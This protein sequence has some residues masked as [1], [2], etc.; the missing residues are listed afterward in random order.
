MKNDDLHL[1]SREEQLYLQILEDLNKPRGDGLKVDLKTRLHNDQIE[2]LKPL[3]DEGNEINS[4]FLA[5]GRKYG[6]TELMAYALWRHALLNPNS[7]CYYVAPENNHAR[8]IL[9]R[10]GR[11]QKFL[12]EDCKK[13]IKK[14]TDQDMTI[15]FKNG[16]FI[17]LIGSDNYMVANGLTP[18]I[19]VYDEFKGFNHRWHTEFAPNRAAKAAPL[20]I[21]GTKPRSGN[22]N[23]DQYDEILEY[24][25]AHPKTWYVAER[26]TFDNPINHLPAQKEVIEQEIAQL[27]ARG[28][29]DVVQLEY[30][31]RRI[32]GGKRAIFPMFDKDKHVFAH[33]ELYNKIKR[34][35]KKLDWYIIKDPGTVTC[36]GVLIA[37]INPYSKEIYIL[38]EI[39]ETDQRETSTRKIYPRSE[40][41][42]LELY[43]GSNIHDDF[44]K[45]ADE[46]AAWYMNEVMDQ[47]GVYFSPTSK[48]HNKKEDGISLIKDIMLFNLI[49]ISDRCTNLAIEIDKYALDDRGNIPKKHDHLIDCLRY[50]LAAAHYNMHEM[51]E[52]VRTRSDKD[53][54]QKNRFR[55]PGFEDEEPKDW[56]ANVFKDWT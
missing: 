14:I 26:T 22:K 44:I 19:A 51:L 9:W 30:Y 40:A 37:A 5:C 32:S 12:A 6:K 29:E 53:T 41:K 16:S 43:P 15:W 47:F 18:S 38:D 35:V 45:T 4:M 21:I 48:N 1:I 3:Y 52:A 28:E 42:A 2:Q 39:Y 56:M 54:I 49:Q 17:R 24:A 25:K 50:L 8:E 13:Y 31:S 7:S 55:D 33:D 36:F 11:I 20:I 27:L 46:A 10:N 34:D 23:M